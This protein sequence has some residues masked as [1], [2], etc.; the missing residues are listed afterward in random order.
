MQ[1]LD[2]NSFDQNHVYTLYET[3]KSIKEK[4]DSKHD[5]TESELKNFDLVKLQLETIEN[6]SRQKMQEKLHWTKEEILLNYGHEPSLIVD[7][8]VGSEGY[9]KYG[10]GFAIVIEFSEEELLQM[11]E[12]I[13]N[14]AERTSGTI[15]FKITHDNTNGQMETGDIFEIG[16]HRI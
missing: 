13:Q 12:N 3:Y 14:K 8:H 15:N 7:L 11:F 16:G 2:I 9:T 5:K 6:W 4:L 10:T 1:I